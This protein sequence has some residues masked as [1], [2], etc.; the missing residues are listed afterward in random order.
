MEIELGEIVRDQEERFFAAIG[1]IVLRS[2]N[3]LF[4]IAAGFID[5]FG[6]QSYILVRPLNTVKRRFGLIAHKHA[7]S[8][9]CLRWWPYLINSVSSLSLQTTCN[10]KTAW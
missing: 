9:A 3:L 5:G 8:T 1:S 6:E 7:L 10:V 2:R 4:H